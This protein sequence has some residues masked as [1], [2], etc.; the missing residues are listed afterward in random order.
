MWSLL[1]FPALIFGYDNCSGTSSYN[2]TKV[3]GTIAPNPMAPTQSS[4]ELLFTVCSVINRCNPQVTYEACEAGVL[5]DPINSQI[6]APPSYP[7]FS[8]VMQAEQSGILF[9]SQSATNACASTINGL[10]CS[11][12]NVQNAYNS[13]SPTPFAGA[14]GM[15]PTATCNQVFAPNQNFQWTKQLGESG[16]TTQISSYS[17]AI[18][19]DSSGNVYVTGYTSGNLP[20][21]NGTSTNCAGSSHGST[22]YFVSKYTGAGA[23]LWTQQ[24]GAGGGATGGIAVSVDSL[25]NVYVTG[26]TQTNLI[27]CNGVSTNCIG[28]SQGD[29]D[30]FVSKYSSSGAWE[31]TQQL[32]ETG[33]VTSSLG[34]AVDSSG[35][36]YV[37]GYTS[38]NLV[39]CNGVSTNCAGNSQGTNDYFIS[40]YTSAGTWLWTQQL[41]ESG[42]NT[43]GDAITLDPQGNIF[44]TGLTGG[45]NLTSCNGVSSQCSGRSQGSADYFISKYTS[46]GT[47]VWTQQ[48]GE[49]GLLSSGAGITSDAAGNIYVTGDT[50]GNLVTCNGISTNCAGSSQGSQDNF[51]SKYTNS[52]VWVWTG[53]LGETGKT[54]FGGGIVVD[55]QENIYAT[56]YT[57]GNLVSCNGI[58]G[59]CS[60]NSQGAQDYFIS[61]YASSGVWIQTQQLG[62]TGVATQAFGAILDSSQNVYISGFTSGNLVSCNGVSAQCTGNSQGVSDYF[63]SKY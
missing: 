22:D 26:S 35:N 5:T 34:L 32:G 36:S 50:A 15:I 30:Y 33:I 16:K 63:I 17:G 45:G 8:S 14:S 25:N 6:G 58:S 10:S 61:K 57:N 47:W 55:S 1:L 49:T 23:W 20:S 42:A 54:T 39:S 62:Q 44:I 13:S 38:G 56:G 29:V 41:G 52:G 60:G 24:L 2:F 51:I 11:N 53:Q 43:L 7:T 12:P 28:G 31:W 4:A 48:L 18:A 9:G 21:C 19:L 40:K 3:N 46:A 27:S 59:N 37:V